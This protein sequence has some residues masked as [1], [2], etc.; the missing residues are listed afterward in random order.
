MLKRMW[1][2]TAFN[3][4]LINDT[5]GALK[6]WRVYFT[7]TVLKSTTSCDYWTIEIFLHEKCGT[8]YFKKKKNTPKLEHS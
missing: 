8:L 2:V 3:I 1:K 6:I 4:V 5:E 7:C